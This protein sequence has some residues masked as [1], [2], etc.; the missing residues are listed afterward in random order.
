MGRLLGAKQR[1]VGRLWVGA[2]GA[3]ALCAAC[4][5]GDPSDPADPM[6]SSAAP[7]EPGEFTHVPRIFLDPAPRG[8]LPPG[9]ELRRVTLK[10][11]DLTASMEG[12]RG[13]L[14]E[15][16]AGYCTIGFGHLVKL[17]PCDGTEP[18][19]FRHGLDRPAARELLREDL[20]LAERAVT[21]LVDVPLSDGQY[22]ALCDFTYNVG[23]GA[24]ARSTLRDYVN[25]GEYGKVPAQLRRYVLAGGRR[26]RGL[27]VR[28]E[29][30][31]ELFFDG[32]VPRS[33]PGPDEDLTPIDI[34]RP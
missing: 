6:G 2:V 29:K 27:V 5:G 7:T 16:P 22:D 26:L 32:L 33:V 21:E 31:I 11:L 9:V 13:E 12:Y 18:A 3:L 24:L 30:E 10:G 25:A 20:Q 1:E 28:R 8:P 19:R 23:R 15:D 34:L 14:Y 17:S 4:A